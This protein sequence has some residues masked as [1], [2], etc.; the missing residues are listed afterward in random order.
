MSDFYFM[1]LYHKPITVENFNFQDKLLI[2]NK[3]GF[4]N[5]VFDRDIYRTVNE[6]SKNLQ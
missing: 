1:N 5:S 2:Y 3:Q 4:H 6:Y